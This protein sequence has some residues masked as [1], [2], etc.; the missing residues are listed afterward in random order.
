MSS[1]IDNLPSYKIDPYVLE[2]SKLISQG[3]DILNLG[4]INPN[5]VPPPGALNKLVEASLRAYNHRYSSSRGI[6]DLRE[7]VKAWY[8][9]RHK[10]GGLDELSNI[11]ITQGT[12]EGIA[13]FLMANCQQGDNVI[14]G[15]PSYPIHR[16]AI[17]LASANEVTV[18]LYESFSNL[19]LSCFL[20]GV[21]NFC[22]RSKLKFVILNFPNN[23]TGIVANLEFYKKILDLSYK[24]DF[25]LINDFTYGDL[26]F[27][28]NLKSC[29]LLSVEGA[30]ERSVEFY[31][32]SKVLSLSGWRTGFAVGNQILIDRLYKLKSYIDFGSFVPIQIASIDVLG[33][34][35]SYIQ[36]IREEFFSRRMM[37]EQALRENNWDVLIHNSGIFLWASLPPDFKI[38]DSE[39]L[40]W[41][42]LY[43][44]DILALP[45][46]CF[47]D[48]NK[49]TLRFSL[50]EPLIRL[51]KAAEKIS[52]II[53]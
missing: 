40:C 50:G 7:A 48:N 37:F 38:Q 12:K 52:K 4:T 26:V 24:Y 11:C 34:F 14:I 53:L 33:K 20:E 32:L 49:T 17:Y 42:L 51:Q 2:A 46:T 18:P 8:L 41:Q 19:D 35:D 16:A 29:S 15:T 5:F 1:P 6:K 43:K 31:S 21:E 9:D 25:Y 3:R 45:G 44:G 10:V 36:L 47:N 13:H 30:K 23:P 22:K 28:E 27:D 39:E